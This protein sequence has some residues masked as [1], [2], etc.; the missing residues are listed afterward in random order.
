MKH[1][2]GFAAVRERVG[3]CSR[4]VSSGFSLLIHKR[5]IAAVP[6][7]RQ[8]SAGGVGGPVKSIGPAAKAKSGGGSR[9]SGIGNGGGSGR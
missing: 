8:R 2:K 5:V 7:V 6:V 9:I 3:V 1:V 4:T